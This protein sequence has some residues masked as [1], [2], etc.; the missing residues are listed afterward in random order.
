MQSMSQDDMPPDKCNAYG[1]AH[2]S[3]DQAWSS[4]LELLDIV[5]SHDRQL[6]TGFNLRMGHN[7]TVSSIY[8][9]ILGAMISLWKAND[10]HFT[11]KIIAKMRHFHY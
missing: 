9:Y 6:D 10:L 4:A 8:W 5:F 2:D 1:V 7:C 11:H 3:Y